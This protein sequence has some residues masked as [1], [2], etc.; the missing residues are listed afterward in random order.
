MLFFCIFSLKHFFRVKHFCTVWWKLD[1][2]FTRRCH[3][4]KLLTIDNVRQTQGDHNS[5]PRAFLLW[6]ANKQ[7]FLYIQWYC[8]PRT[9]HQTSFWIVKQILSFKSRPLFRRVVKA[10]LIELLPLEVYTLHWKVTG[11]SWKILLTSC[12]ERE[13]LQAEDCLSNSWNLTRIRT[14]NPLGRG[15]F[16]P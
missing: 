11:Y 12:K 15:H 1:Q 8:K 2:L 13:L 10:V 5:S 16:G 6:W 7:I 14:N 9:A 3:L 4:K